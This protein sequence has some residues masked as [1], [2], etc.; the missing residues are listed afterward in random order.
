MKD[1]LHKPDQPELI[2][3]FIKKLKLCKKYETIL[4]NKYV[5]GV[6]DKIQVQNLHISTR[7]YYKL[8]QTIHVCAYDSMKR[9]IRYGS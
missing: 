4:Q 5:F 1:I 6:V 8:L 3:L 7:Q 2:D 9:V